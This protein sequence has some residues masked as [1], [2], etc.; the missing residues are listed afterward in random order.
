MSTCFSPVYCAAP[1]FPLASSEA[2]QC[3][4]VSND[5]TDITPV[6]QGAMVEQEGARVRSA[7]A[8]IELAES[9]EISQGLA[10]QTLAVSKAQHPRGHPS[11]A[12][13]CCLVHVLLVDDLCNDSPLQPRVCACK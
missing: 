9:G 7:R 2:L 8:A 13:S 4:L 3:D 1:F 11:S 12:A 6:S 5:G 10:L